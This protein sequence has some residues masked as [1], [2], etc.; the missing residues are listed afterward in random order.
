ML[1]HSWLICVWPFFLFELWSLFCTG[2]LSSITAW[3]KHINIFK[4]IY[5]LKYNKPFNDKEYSQ[6][7]YYSIFWI[8]FPRLFNIVVYMS[9]K[10]TDISYLWLNFFNKYWFHQFSFSTLTWF[11]FRCSYSYFVTWHLSSTSIG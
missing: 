7:I 9:S 5:I 2:P 8:Y 10:Q 4:Y 11:T 3:Q 6:F 1:K